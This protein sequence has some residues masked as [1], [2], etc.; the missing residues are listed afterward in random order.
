MMMFTLSDC[1]I[2]YDD[3]SMLLMLVVLLLL[4]IPTFDLHDV[5]IAASC[6]GVCSYFVDMC[7]VYDDN[8]VYFV[9]L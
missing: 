2:V 6:R 4:F 7:S 8:Y 9:T 5:V 3:M 1:L